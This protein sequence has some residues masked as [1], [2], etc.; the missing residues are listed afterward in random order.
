MMVLIMSTTAV[1]SITPAT[2]E[3]PNPDTRASPHPLSFLDAFG[4]SP[5]V[6]APG[7][8]D[9]QAYA[10]PKA[11]ADLPAIKEPQGTA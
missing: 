1:S 11:P 3:I 10:D 8:S 5:V 6:F 7:S 9:P 2:F 4:N